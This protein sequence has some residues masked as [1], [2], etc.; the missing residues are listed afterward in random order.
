MDRLAAKVHCVR[1]VLQSSHSRD[2]SGARRGIPADESRL[3]AF[4]SIRCG[5]AAAIAGGGARI[6][7]D[8]PIGTVGKS[9]G[10]DE[11]RRALCAEWRR[12]GGPPR[13]SAGRPPTSA[14]ESAGG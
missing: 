3:S 13:N 11:R 8:A 10:G 1:G 4:G 14:A 5:R 7:V 6:D 12:E 2:A 9:G